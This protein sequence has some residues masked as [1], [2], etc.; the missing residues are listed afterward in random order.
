MN[1]TA[2]RTAWLTAAALAML[3]AILWFTV[4]DKPALG[5]VFAGVAV[6]F[7]ALGSS[8]RSHGGGR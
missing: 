6:T 2:T 4:L 7:F 5:A 3:A 8:D 1:G